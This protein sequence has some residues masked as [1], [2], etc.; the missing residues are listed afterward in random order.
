MEPIISGPPAHSPSILNTKESIQYLES[1]LQKLEERRHIGIE[2][3]ERQ[4]KAIYEDGQRQEENLKRLEIAQK[5]LDGTAKAVAVGTAVLVILEV[6]KLGSDLIR[7]LVRKKQEK[8]KQDP[9]DFQEMDQAEGFE[10]SN[11]GNEKI[12]KRYHARQW[13]PNNF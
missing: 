1:K 7:W 4:K 10:T 9:H 3:A 6:V 13:L 2:A 8:L 5:K 12:G 11:D